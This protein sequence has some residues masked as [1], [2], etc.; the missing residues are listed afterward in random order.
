[1]IKPGTA[2]EQS[3][4]CSSR[5][6]YPSWC[7]C[8]KLKFNCS[9]CCRCRY[10]VNGKVREVNPFKDK[11]N[12]CRRCSR[13]KSESLSACS[14]TFGKYK[15]RYPCL[16]IKELVQQTAFVL[17]VK[18]LRDTSSEN[19]KNSKKVPR[20]NREDKNCVRGSITKYLTMQGEEFPQNAWTLEEVVLLYCIVQFLQNNNLEITTGITHHLYTKPQEINRADLNNRTKSLKQRE[21]KLTYMQRM[22]NRQWFQR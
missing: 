13:G 16:K 17:V 21:A 8:L 9:K 12:S 6:S 22:Q 19:S 18:I 1:M 7:P 3:S 2:V 10:W 15:S 14:N 5:E 11:L 20:G 4:S